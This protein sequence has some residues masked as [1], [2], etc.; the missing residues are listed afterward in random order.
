MKQENWNLT[1][2]RKKC[3][4]LWFEILITKTPLCE[5][6]GK[7]ATQIHHFIPK[8]LSSFLRY[9]LL[10]GISLCV[11]CHFA[12]HSKADPNITAA[13]ISI[14]GKKWFEYINANRRNPVKISKTYY[15]EIFKRLYEQQ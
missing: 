1:L 10:N 9:D 5:V 12:H 13:I 6:C 2:W 7:T 14:R 4:K 8:S 3:D 15:Q 11:G